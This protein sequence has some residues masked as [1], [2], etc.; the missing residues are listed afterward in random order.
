MS[1]K[2]PRHKQQVRTTAGSAYG[3]N[4]YGHPVWEVNRNGKTSRL[5]Y[6]PGLPIAGTTI[7]AWDLFNGDEI[8]E[9]S[10]MTRKPTIDLAPKIQAWLDE[11]M[12]LYGTGLVGSGGRGVRIEFPA[13]QYLVSHLDLRPGVQFVGLSSRYEVQFIQT[14]DYNADHF[15]TILGHLDNSDQLQRRTEVFIADISFEAN[16]LLADDGSTLD[17]VHAEPETFTDTDPDAT[18][19]RTGII[20]YRFSGEGASGWG[21][22]SLKR[23]KN[24][25]HECQFARNGTASDPNNSGGIYVQGPDSKFEKVYCGSNYGDQ[26]VIKSSETP[27][28][29]DV[30]LGTTKSDPTQ[31]VSLHLISVT[32]AFI[33]GGNSTGPMLFE[34]GEGDT[35][36]NEYGIDCWI[37]VADVIFTFKDKT[38]QETGTSA[39]TLPGYIW[40]KNIKGVVIDNCRYHPAYDDGTTDPMVHIVTNRPTNII[41]ITG[42]RTT[43]VFRGHLP[44]PTDNMWPAGSPERNPA[45]LSV[46]TDPLNTTITN[47]PK[48]LSIVVTDPTNTTHS[49]YF[50][51]LGFLS[52]GGLTG[53]VSGS[54]IST[55]IVGEAQTLNVTSTGT[56]ALSTAGSVGSLGSISIGAGNWDIS[57]RVIFTSTG[58]SASQVQAGI[59]AASSTIPSQ[60]ADRYAV[61]ALSVA[62]FNGGVAT[63]TIG[64]FLSKSTAAATWYLNAAETVS[65]GTMSVYGSMMARR[66]A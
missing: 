25:L 31:Y 63:L 17:C 44:P 45:G 49:W 62:A 65:A 37:N 15:I 20:G 33:N 8:A 22:N 57:G 10:D 39:A 26:F 23:G 41:D 35:S 2:W 9:I 11:A 3:Q 19:T 34:G 13:G 6:A 52:G 56:V 48:Q 59:S 36:A 61:Q 58:V 51:N 29:Y 21:Y 4:E 38:F 7:C 5:I 64:P 24:W 50:D 14:D 12:N 1:N 46:P 43:A 54:N 66:R 30:E 27:M 16:G 42:S 18:V 32:S 60:N 28:I 47:K 40:L 55:G 53:D